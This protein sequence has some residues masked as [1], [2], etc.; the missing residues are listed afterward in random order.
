MH[1]TC[2][3]NYPLLSRGGLHFVHQTKLSRKKIQ[4]TKCSHKVN[5]TQYSFTARNSSI[6]CSFMV[7][8]GSRWSSLLR[9]SSSLFSTVPNFVSMSTAL[10][11][12]LKPREDECNDLQILPF[13]PTAAR[14]NI[15]HTWICNEFYPALVVTV[16]T[17]RFWLA[18]KLMSR[19][20]FLLAI[21]SVIRFSKGFLN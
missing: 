6:R 20:S 18:P 11:W 9:K 15:H 16:I 17:K 12:L 14:A 1:Q 7:M 13:S 10:N 3:L 8:R 2:S 19:R 21:S 5:T 4:N